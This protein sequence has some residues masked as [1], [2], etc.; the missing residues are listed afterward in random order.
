[1]W[2]REG[3]GVGRVLHIHVFPL[4]QMPFRWTLAR[5]ERKREQA[6]LRVSPPE[7][8]HSLTRQEYN[9]DPQG[10]QRSVE[11]APPTR[12][13][14]VQKWTVP[15]QQ[16]RREISLLRPFPLLSLASE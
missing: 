15:S 7:T 9:Q 11:R 1:M 4:V 2:F 6:L 14:A 8:H 5:E 10:K 13:A 12:R 16:L 3:G